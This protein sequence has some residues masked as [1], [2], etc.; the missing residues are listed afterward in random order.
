MD[1]R[2]NHSSSRKSTPTKEVEDKKGKIN[3]KK[4]NNDNTQQTI[5]PKKKL[6]GSWTG[7]TPL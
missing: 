2:K 4:G 7:K 5:T 3:K 6:F 1:K